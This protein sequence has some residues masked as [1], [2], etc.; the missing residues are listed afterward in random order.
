MATKP[1]LATMLK[2]HGLP[3]VR[4]W[5]DVDDEA[6]I[7]DVRLAFT[8]KLG[9]FID[10]VT[11][12]IQPEKLSAMAEAQVFTETEHAAIALFLNRLSLLGKDCLLVSISVTEK[13]EI[14]FVKRL[15]SEWPGIVTELK[16]LVER[17]KA[18]YA[19]TTL[20]THHVSYLG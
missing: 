4:Q 13:E 18:A 14:A 19:D 12:M 1:S 6:T 15:C 11:D 9:L 17:T 3:E 16:I 8:D 2:E 7:R 10:A 20:S 5:I